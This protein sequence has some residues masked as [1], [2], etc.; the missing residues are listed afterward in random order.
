MSDSSPTGLMI[1]TGEYTTGYVHDASSKSDKGAGVVALTLFDLRR[2]GKLDKLLMA[3]TNGKKFP[4]IRKHLQSQIAERYANIDV[5]FSSF[6]EDDV[7]RDP[8]AYLGALDTMRAGDFVTVFTPDPTHFEIA[9]QAVK[10][11]IHVL[12]AKP[13]V[14]TLDEHHALLDE[15]AKT[16]ALVALEVHKR[17][18]P[19]YAD[20][21]DRIQQLGDFSN[22]YS[23]MSQPKSQLETFKNWAAGSDISYYL[24][25]HHV[26]FHAWCLQSRA[27][28][29]IVYATSA[30]GV[31]RSQGLETED[32]ISLHVTWENIESKSQGM[33][34]YTSSWIAPPADVHSQQRFFYMGHGGE[35][36]MDQAHRGFSMATDDSGY[37]S[38]N[39][40]F[41][42]Y[43][44]GTD[45]EFAG[46]AGYGYRSI[47]AFVDAVLQLNQGDCQPG[48][49]ASRL[50]LA[51]D[52]LFVTAILEA[53]RR[54]L[55]S[56]R[57]QRLVFDSQGRPIHCHEVEAT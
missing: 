13:L 52:T 39:P 14:K 10:R 16:G 49:F 17:W 1:G 25:A 12:L 51:G 40:L 11:G 37:A 7:A 19:L 35:V 8:I 28:P 53:G 48:D 26:D 9:M 3:G 42:K 24:N 36:T 21:R 15:A 27:V 34:T 55:D 23:Y 4:A 45:G 44:P 32:T 46:Q 54:S 5:D 43:T 57:P 18:D 20:A 50:A 22:F 47:E 29:K 41:M 2:R 38:V 33:A 31:A 56:G 30:D 6:P